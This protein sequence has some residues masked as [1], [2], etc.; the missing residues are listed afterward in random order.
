MSNTTKYHKQS[1]RKYWYNLI[2][3]KRNPIPVET[4]SLNWS[5]DIIDNVIDL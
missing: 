1:Y 2:D 5:L 3:P 4:V